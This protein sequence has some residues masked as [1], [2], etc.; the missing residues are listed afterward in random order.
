MTS[1]NGAH[2]T[3]DILKILDKFF[4]MYILC[5]NKKYAELVI[6]VEGKEVYGLC[7]ACGKKNEYDP[8]HKMTKYLRN[9]PPADLKKLTRGV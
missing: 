4:D 9:H 3:E 5:N 1:I 2:E 7:D 8:S 6:H